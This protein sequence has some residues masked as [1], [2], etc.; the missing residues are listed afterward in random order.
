MCLESILAQTYK[1]LEIICIDDGSTDN[2]GKICESFAKLDQ[3]IKVIHKKNGGLS[4]ARNE[5]IRNAHGEFISFIDGDDKIK[6]NT[7]EKVV[8]ALASEAD[9]VWF[10][11]GIVY[12]AHSEYEKSDKDYYSIK[13]SG[14]RVLDDNMLYDSDCSACNKIFNLKHIK[15]N[16]LYFTEGILYEDAL[17]YWKYF[18]TVKSAYF[19]NENLYLYYRRD[20]SI[21]SSTFEKKEDK[22]IHHIFIMDYL[23][24]FWKN[25]NIL[26]QKNSIFSKLL[27]AYF[28]FAVRNSPDFE[29]ARC[30]WEMTKRLR[31]WDI[32]CSNDNTLS[33]LK[34]GQYQIFFG[35]EKAIPSSPKVK[36]MKP[37]ERLFCVRREG[38]H[39]VVR[40]F[41]LKIASKRKKI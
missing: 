20:G 4:S 2:S 24:D 11:I 39:K 35:P 16:E 31:A 37:L 28:W 15:D 6:I 18:S 21:M 38:N 22:A 3:R 29:K 30:V 33:Y 13:Y 36:K 19:I 10:G 26:S 41:G 12:E 25:K 40:L 9:V 17:F 27:L 23:Y 1:N 32:D 34:E 5:G 8:D 14:K 7:Y